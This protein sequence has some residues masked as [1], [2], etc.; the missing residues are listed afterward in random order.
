[1]KKVSLYQL[2]N[3]GF[4]NLKKKVI[5]KR[6]SLLVIVAI[7]IQFSIIYYF[8]LF[9]FCDSW[10]IVARHQRLIYFNNYTPIPYASA[11]LYTLKQVSINS[12][13]YLPILLIVCNNISMKNGIK[14]VKSLTLLKKRILNG[15]LHFQC[16]VNC[17]LFNCSIS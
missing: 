11:E 4:F 1:M 14:C 8:K 10:L 13:P 17:Q 9:F 2:V 7:K 6:H 3:T 16:S 5:L 15:K 12:K